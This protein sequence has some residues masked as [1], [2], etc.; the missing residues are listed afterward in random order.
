MRLILSL[1]DFRFHPLCRASMSWFDANES[2][3]TPRALDGPALSGRFP[4]LKENELWIPA[5]R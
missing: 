1:S 2:L 4:T 3:R 5:K